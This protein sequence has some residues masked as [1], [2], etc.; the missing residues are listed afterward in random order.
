[1]GTHAAHGRWYACHS[2]Q[3]S[4]PMWDYAV[5]WVRVGGVG[6]AY[7]GRVSETVNLWGY[8]FG[9]CSTAF[10]LLAKYLKMTRVHACKGNRTSRSRPAENSI[11]AATPF[12][13]RTASDR[14]PPRQRLV[15]SP[16]S[17]M[18]PQP[19]PVVSQS[20]RSAV[21]RGGEPSDATT[22][23]GSGPYLFRPWPRRASSPSRGASVRCDTI[24]P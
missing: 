21:G 4:S 12:E 15:P 1:M 11:R 3:Y 2:T 19:W 23:S 17:S 14:A 22:R 20:A 18:R 6:R 24:R 8:E 7:I 5:A 9:H 13:G 16:D 10:C